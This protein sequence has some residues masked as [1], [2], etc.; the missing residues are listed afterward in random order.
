[1]REFLGGPLRA[2]QIRL[3][4]DV[5]K[6]KI[7]A[8][9]H[10]HTILVLVNTYRLSTFNIT[11]TI[12]YGCREYALRVKATNLEEALIEDISRC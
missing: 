12:G 5:T 9:T 1:L 10:V 4:V 2:P 11:Y 3:L 6:W 8:Q 7:S